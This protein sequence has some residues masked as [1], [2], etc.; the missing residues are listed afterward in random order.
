MNIKSMHNDIEQTLH[1]SVPFREFF[2]VM[3][4][5]VRR[6]NADIEHAEQMVNMIGSEGYRE[7]IDQMDILWD[8]ADQFALGVDALHSDLS[9]NDELYSIEMPNSW[10]KLM[11]VY[12]DGKRMKSVSFDRL[13]SGDCSDCYTSVNQN[14]FF[15]IDYMNSN[16]VIDAR[17]RKEYELPKIGELEYSGMPNNAYSLIMAAVLSSLLARPQY[18]D[19]EMLQFYMDQY[20]T[21][22][23]SFSLDNMLRQ[24]SS[25]K[26]K[27]NTID[28]IYKGD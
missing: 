19:R 6:I 20:L 14:I 18:H 3:A 5:A 7:T 10:V 22:S 26:T 27:I 13:H 1:R 15:S 28:P 17:I 16:H 8:E 4:N 25:I 24:K 11:A 23:R 2:A 12:I 21:Q 9:W